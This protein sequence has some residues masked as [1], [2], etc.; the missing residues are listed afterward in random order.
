MTR[1]P[2]A[3]QPANE[4]SAP[5]VVDLADRLARVTEHWAP[6]VVAR[7]NDYEIKVVKVR[8][9]FVFHTH[10]YTDELFLV[11]SGELTIQRATATLCCVRGSCSS[12]RAEWST[13][14]SP[15][16]R[17]TQ[18]DRAAGRGQHRKC[19]RPADCDVRRLVGLIRAARPPHCAS[20]IDSSDGAAAR[21]SRFVTRIMT[22]PTTTATS[23]KIAAARN[24]L[25][26]PWA[27]AW[28]LKSR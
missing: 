11:L 18:T 9:E 19:R 25:P 20:T 4:T 6:K 26:A 14:R 22:D 10:E 2:I 7:L 27:W 21:T 24:A 12:S 15:W 28:W 13:A 5:G 17:Y 23:A 1:Q 16:A 3:R 8:G